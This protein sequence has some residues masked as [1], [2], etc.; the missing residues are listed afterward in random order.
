METTTN[1]KQNAAGLNTNRFEHVTIRGYRIRVYGC[2]QD[3]RTGQFFT[4]YRRLDTLEFGKVRSI[5]FGRFTRVAEPKPSSAP[6]PVPQ[7][8][9][10]SL[11][12]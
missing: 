8:I 2:E 11:G 12:I 3:E 4:L 10:A 6:V 9:Q 1:T 7:I 5:D